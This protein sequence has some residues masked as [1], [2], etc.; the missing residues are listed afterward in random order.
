MYNIYLPHR[1]HF[2][3]GASREEA[4]I[5]SYDSRNRKVVMLYVEH[6][7]RSLFLYRI[8][9]PGTFPLHNAAY[10]AAW[11]PHDV[12]YTFALVAN[13]LWDPSRRE[14]PS[15]WQP[16]PSG[17]TNPEPE[18]VPPS[19]D[20]WARGAIPSKDA[21]T[22]PCTSLTPSPRSTNDDEDPQAEQEL[23]GNTSVTLKDI[24]NHAAAGGGEGGGQHGKGAAQRG[25][26]AS[27]P[28]GRVNRAT[29]AHNGGRD[30]G[31]GRAWGGGD[32]E[33]EEGEIMELLRTLS[34]ED[35][36]RGEEVLAG[37][38]GIGDAIGRGRR[39]EERAFLEVRSTHPVRKKYVAF[40]LFLLVSMYSPTGEER[41]VRS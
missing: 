26:A 11:L 37:A 2:S 16:L 13:F 9:A 12:P 6:V 29:D 23:G 20:N 22:I 39:H 10:S 14:L 28:G 32:G 35:H 25:A 21:S 38:G 19:I 33:E 8:L 31:D 36:N 27:G 30:Q 15:L 5:S 41:A 34:D 4:Y 3:R 7:N 17:C 18:P 40:F 24:D 1:L